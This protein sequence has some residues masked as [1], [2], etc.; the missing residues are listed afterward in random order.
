[1]ETLEV[2]CPDCGTVLIVN[3][4]TGGVL[5]TRKPDKEEE[6]QVKENRFDEARRRAKESEERAAKK[7]KAAQE[8]EK[9]KFAKLDA[10]FK[11]RKKEI[12]DDGE[13]IGR[14][15]SPFDLD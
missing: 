7:F 14:P 12:E 13:E 1:M 9:D 8:A 4:L 11:D 5:E 10:L 3:R 2:I 15:A 6:K